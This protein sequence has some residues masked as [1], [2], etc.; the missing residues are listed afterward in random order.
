MSL[1]TIHLQPQLLVDL[2]TRSLLLSSTTSVPESS[3]VKYLGKNQKNILILVQQPFVPCLK[4]EELSF[5]TSILS[6]CKLSLA[7]IA[8]L[9]SN[10]LPVETLENAIE[11]DA[12]TVILFGL[13]PL[14]I[15]LPINFPFFQIQQFNKRMYLY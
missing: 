7:D 15:G 12:K 6:A 13:D 14:S 10:G 3:T 8:I 9:N 4:D 2:Y 5:L 1:N 11:S